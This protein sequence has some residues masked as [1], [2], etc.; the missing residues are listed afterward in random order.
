[1]WNKMRFLVMALAMALAATAPMV[2]AQDLQRDPGDTDESQ[3]DNHDYGDRASIDRYLD[4]E[5]WT[6]HGDN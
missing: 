1:M 5:V 2:A 4:A 6:N 3:Y